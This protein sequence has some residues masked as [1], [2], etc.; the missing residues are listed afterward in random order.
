MPADGRVVVNVPA[1]ERGSATYLFGLVKVKESSPYDV[2]AI[3]IRRGEHTIRKLSI[4]DLAK[5]PVDEQ[6][7]RLVRI[8]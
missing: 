4:N 8:E 3:H 1:L 6:G 2:P 5:L 7:Y